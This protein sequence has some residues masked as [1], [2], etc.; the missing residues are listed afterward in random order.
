MSK[1]PY[2]HLD[3]ETKK[4]ITELIY[5]CNNIDLGNVSFEYGPTR[6]HFYSVYFCMREFTSHWE[7]TVK[8]ERKEEGKYITLTDIYRFDGFNIIYEC[9]E[10][11]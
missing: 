2:Y 4:Y 6:E 11:D 5:T 9:S 3:E 8:H 1:K 7:L 10:E